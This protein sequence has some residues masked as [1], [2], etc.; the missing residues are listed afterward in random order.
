MIKIVSKNVIKD[1]KK[2]DFIKLAKELVEK[3]RQ[4]EGCLSYG[5]FQDINND[6]VFT[7]IEEW[8]DQKAIET[9]NKSEHFTRIIP[10]LVEFRVGE[11][12]LNLYKEV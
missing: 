10:L 12:E 9:H 7:F 2:E 8:K 1:E 11:R 3:S 4:E 6:S 5:L